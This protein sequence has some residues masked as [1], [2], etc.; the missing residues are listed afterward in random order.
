MGL[1][2]DIV[3]PEG[4]GEST[5]R[6]RITVRPKGVE[7][8]PDFDERVAPAIASPQVEAAPAARTGLFD[9]IVPP[10]ARTRGLFDDIVPPAARIGGLFDDIVPPAD[11]PASDMPTDGGQFTAPPPDGG[12]FRVA[13]KA[14]KAATGSALPDAVPWRGRYPD[15]VDT[16]SELM[17][18]GMAADD[19]TGRAAVRF[20]D[21]GA[22]AAGRIGDVV[23]QDD[24]ADIH[25]APAPPNLEPPAL[26][27]GE[28]VAGARGQA[29]PDGAQAS[30][31]SAPQSDGRRATGEGL[32]GADSAGVEDR[33]QP[34]LEPA[35]AIAQAE[36]PS[37]EPKSGK[38]DASGASTVGGQSAGNDPL[39]RIDRLGQA[40]DSRK[41]NSGDADDGGLL[42]DLVNYASH[43]I[44]ALLRI[45]GGLA[46]LAE[47]FKARPV[48][49]VSEVASSFPPA[50]V[51]GELLAGTTSI[52]ASILANAPKGLA[53]EAAAR[54]ALQLAKNTRM[55]NVPGVGR[56]IPDSLT[57]GVT[58]IKNELRVHNRG[59]LRVHAAHAKSQKI[60]FNL[61]VSPTTW[62]ISKD[63]EEAVRK[64]GG[65][66]L[67]FYPATGKFGPY[68]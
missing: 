46:R 51:E 42:Q 31:D 25:P 23:G 6:L 52:F 1:F 63:V 28:E 35:L 67:R 13:R 37:G 3:P 7:P 50:R 11:A 26:G 66:I 10:V 32:G 59:Q 47:E 5:P 43:S 27:V 36:A 19:A 16:G 9:D 54:Q 20:D 38:D 40:P 57:R 21:K 14:M 49:T 62:W 53:F 55:V 17:A 39:H 41:D 58:E 12:N 34:G 4:W 56:S 60:P 24:L 61:V 44:E 8:P 33:A 65:T 2:D 48:D 18:A 30:G 45:P 68:P 22:P 29:P 64:S 15:L